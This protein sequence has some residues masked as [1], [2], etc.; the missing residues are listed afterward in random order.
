MLANLRALFGVIV[1]IVLLR[2]GPEHLPASPAL[3]WSVVALDFVVTAV[4]VAFTPEVP[5]TW[6]L[7][8][9]AGIAILLLWFRVAFNVAKKPERF[10][11]TATAIFGVSILFLP[12]LMPLE[13]ALKPYIPDKVSE[14]PMSLLLPSFLLGAWAIAIQVRIV[15][16]AFEWHWLPSLIFIFAQNMVSVVLL[17]ALFGAGQPGP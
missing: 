13:S 16:S 4:L 14:A 5:R 12:V 11:Q 15:R 1:D 17:G 6:V 2:R 10:L 7:Q 3:L 9:I 8:V